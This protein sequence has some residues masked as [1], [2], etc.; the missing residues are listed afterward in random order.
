MSRHGSGCISLIAKRKTD[1]E[2]TSS[3][4]ILD[5]KVGR[6]KLLN[7]T[8]TEEGVPVIIKGTIEGACG[9]DD[10]VSQEFT[11]IVE[12]VTLA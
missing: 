5:V 12:E 1:M 11:V 6:Q 10:G 9:Q 7:R 3:F 2:I 4:A 8:Q